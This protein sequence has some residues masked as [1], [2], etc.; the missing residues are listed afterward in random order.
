MMC[1]ILKY[2]KKK[3]IKEKIKEKKEI[4]KINKRGDRVAK[5]VVSF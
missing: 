2:L 4:D 1:F 3:E 5:R